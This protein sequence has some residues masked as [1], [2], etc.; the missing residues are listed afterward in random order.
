MILAN[1]AENGLIYFGYA[2]GAGIV[3]FAIFAAIK[4][5]KFSILGGRSEFLCDSCKYNDQR[6]CSVPDRPNVKKCGDY[7][8]VV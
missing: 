3:L 5:G 6:Y 7:K 1:L 2:I 4:R 8:S